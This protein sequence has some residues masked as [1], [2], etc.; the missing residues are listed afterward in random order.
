VPAV[1][2]AGTLSSGNPVGKRWGAMKKVLFILAVAL[3]FI[4]AGALSCR[5]EEDLYKYEGFR[6]TL[7]M[8]EMGC[9]FPD[10]VLPD[11]AGNPV[12]FSDY[13]GSVILLSFCSCYTDTCCA[14]VDA[15]EELK[16][17]YAAEGLV[18]LVVCSEIAPVLEKDGYAGILGQCAEAADVVLIDEGKRAKGRFE[19]RRLPTTF[20]LDASFCSRYK[21]T[22]AGA[23]YTKTFRDLL[24]TVLK[25]KP[26]T[27]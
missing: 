17:S 15:L 23:L 27:E 20:L 21:V 14:I 9:P 11:S 5:G 1:A 24:E 26:G 7:P 18:T 19:I 4:M 3:N 10:Y 22:T 16:S 6:L 2:A 25:E 13:A 8:P 12:R